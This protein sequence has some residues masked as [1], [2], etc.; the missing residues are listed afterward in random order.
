MHNF[1][2]SLIYA[3]YENAKDCET[4]TEH[5]YKTA[6][7]SRYNINLSSIETKLI[8]DVG[9]FC[10]RYA[11][12]LFISWNEVK[13]TIDCHTEPKTVIGIGIR[14]DGVDG[15]GYIC[16]NLESESTRYHYYRKV[17][18]VCIEHNDLDVNVTLKDISNEITTE[19]Y[20]RSR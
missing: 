10:E 4:I 20:K 9:R 7:G 16:H 19:A 18:A 8:Q 15:N 5:G 14:R 12:D 1:D 3:A 13:E 11:G 17:Y 2:E 6:F